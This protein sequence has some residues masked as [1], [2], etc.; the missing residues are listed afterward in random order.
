MPKHLCLPAI[1][2]NHNHVF[3]QPQEMVRPGLLAVLSPVGVGLAFR[4]LGAYT[5]QELLG[6]KAVASLLMFSLATGVNCSCV[7]QK[8]LPSSAASRFV[9]EAACSLKCCESRLLWLTSVRC[10]GELA[11]MCPGQMQHYQTA[12][13]RRGCRLAL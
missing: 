5:G 11:G 1:E 12:H 7:G 4:A 2:T 13:D 3:W 8:T 6:A 9:S 10:H